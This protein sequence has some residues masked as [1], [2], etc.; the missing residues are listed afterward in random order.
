[1]YNGIEHATMYHDKHGSDMYAPRA[2]LPWLGPSDLW[3]R[4]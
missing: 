4:S 1:M 2:K 3:L